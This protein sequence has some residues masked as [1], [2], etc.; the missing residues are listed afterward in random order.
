MNTLE[1]AAED[2]A[3]EAEQLFQEILDF[4]ELLANENEEEG[5]DF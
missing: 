1:Q 4:L 3:R 5:L 2:Y